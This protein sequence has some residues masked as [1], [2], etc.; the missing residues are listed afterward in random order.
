M[1]FSN[2]RKGFTLIELL[3][4]IAIIAIL[5]AILFPV[6]AKA[7]EKARQTSCASNLKQLGLAFNIYA[8]DF[9]ERLP[10]GNDGASSTDGAGWAAQIYTDVKSTGVYKCP[11]DP[12]QAIVST[13]SGLWSPNPGLSTSNTETE[14]PI[15]Y[16]LNSNIAGN[17]AL[18]S[19]N[20][21][22]IT[23]LLFE[24]SGANGDVTAV[25]NA[26][27]D[28]LSGPSG[29]GSPDTASIVPT[30][31]A[32]IT[33]LGGLE[34]SSATTLYE[35][36]YLAQFAGLA[37]APGNYDGSNTGGGWHSGG[38]NYAFVDTHVKWLRPTSVSAG[39][40]NTVSATDNGTTAI[41]STWTT[42]PKLYAAGTGSGVTATFSLQ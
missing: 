17:G 19:F 35:T 5:A 39:A 12:N 20:A 30:A 34:S 31:T 33:D 25:P 16:G 36:G 18:S 2:T 38:A 41:S 40:S 37:T 13:A 3:V 24:T 10:A 27:E 14:V 22:S 21:P 1:S 15:S 23:V 9:D 32:S 28:N 6:F 29:N 7:R 11:D 26:T 8:E 4:V 42:A